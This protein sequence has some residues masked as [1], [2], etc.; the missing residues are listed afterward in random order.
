VW[1]RIIPQ[2]RDIAPPA[3]KQ[4]L[5]PKNARNAD[6]A[7]LF[8]LSRQKLVYRRASSSSAFANI[9]AVSR[10]VTSA[11]SCISAILVRP[12]KA[13]VLDQPLC[14]AVKSSFYAAIFSF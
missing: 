8:C 10:A 6:S 5:P 1:R 2:M 12:S 9:R 14:G 11:L 13:R 4:N 7:V 3:G